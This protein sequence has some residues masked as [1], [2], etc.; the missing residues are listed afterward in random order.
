MATDSD[1]TLTE[2]AKR[3]MRVAKK[4]LGNDDDARE[5]SQDVLAL[6]LS[7][8][9]S[10]DDITAYGVTVAY[11]AA[12]R[13]S[14]QRAQEAL[15]DPEEL[16]EPSISPS[17][18]DMIV[19]RLYVEDLLAELSPRQARALRLH[20]LEDMKVSEVAANLGVRISTVKSHLKA[21]GHSLRRSSSSTEK[22]G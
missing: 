10:I 9:D 21:G 19:T 6:V 22:A 20:Y 8:R 5:V 14:R 4:V 17:V 13:L 16:P 18:V 2:L 3:T 1:E 7:N 12:V 15:T 11:R